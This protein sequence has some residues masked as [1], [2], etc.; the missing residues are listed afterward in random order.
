MTQD[1]YR[2]PIPFEV[3]ENQLQEALR[4]GREQE[5]IYGHNTG[6]FTLAYEKE[7]TI[8]GVLGEILVRDVLRNGLKTAFSHFDVQLCELGSEFD[9]EVTISGVRSHV[10][11][12][13]GLW[14]NWPRETWEFGVHEDQGIPESGAP[15]ILVTFIKSSNFWPTIG[16]IEGF[17]VSEQLKGA[18]LIKKGN[19]FPSTRVVSRTDNILTKFSEYQ[20]LPRIIDTFKALD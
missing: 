10:H 17:M 4:R 3:N 1:I 13:S 2:K 9:V 12:K 20:E 16:R 5:K 8:I 11:V 18:P 19:L 15:L 7:N 6:H 14:K